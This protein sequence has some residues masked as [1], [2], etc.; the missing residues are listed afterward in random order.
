VVQA[1]ANLAASNWISLATNTASWL[2]IES[3]ANIH[4]QRFYRGVVAH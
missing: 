2:F 1:V 4:G 3:N